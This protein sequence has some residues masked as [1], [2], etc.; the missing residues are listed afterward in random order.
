MKTAPYIYL[1]TKTV[2]EARKAGQ[3]AVDTARNYNV[4][5]PIAVD[6]ESPYI[7]TL[8]VQ[9]LTDVINAFC[10]VIADNGYTPIVYSDFNKLSTEMDTSQIPYDIWLARYRFHEQSVCKPHDLATD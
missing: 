6:I 3:F 1:Q 7:L 8:S 5:F 2:E 4:N 9:E 10:Q